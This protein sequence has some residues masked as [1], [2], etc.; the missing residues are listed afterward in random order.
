MCITVHNPEAPADFKQLE[1]GVADA[2]KA[3]RGGA[4]NTWQLEADGEP[5][6]VR[7]ECASGSYHIMSKI[8]TG[9]VSHAHH[10]AI[11][12][13]DLLPV[14]EALTTFVIDFV[15]VNSATFI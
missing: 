14:Y 7:S 2:R 9:T 10:Q 13:E 15:S 6:S 1:V 5:D 8:V 11:I 3:K 12:R 4:V